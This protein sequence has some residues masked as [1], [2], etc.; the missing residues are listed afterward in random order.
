MKT[1]LD[2]AEVEGDLLL[3]GFPADSTDARDASFPASAAGLAAGG[4]G[5]GPPDFDADLAAR[6]ASWIAR[7]SAFDSAALFSWP[8]SGCLRCAAAAPATDPA[9]AGASLRR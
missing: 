5:A 3:A 9:G 1:C 7:L 2:G 8:P 6:C 4:G